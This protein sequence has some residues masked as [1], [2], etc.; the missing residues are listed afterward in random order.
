[1]ILGGESP[2]FTLA[3]QTYEIKSV[4]FS[5]D[6][7]LLAAAYKWPITVQIWNVK[8]H[9][10]VKTIDSD[11]DRVAFSPDGQSLAIGGFISLN[12][13]Q[14]SNFTEHFIRL[15]STEAQYHD[16][17][18]DVTFSPNGQYVASGT[19]K[20]PPDKYFVEIWQVND[21]TLVQTLL[22]H[23]DRVNSIAFSLDGQYLASASTDG[24][25]RL[26]RTSNW[27]LINML[28]T[29]S[30][31]DSVAF[32]PDGQLLASGGT[33]GTILWR[34]DDG[35]KIATFDT[36]L[37]NSVAFSPDG[38]KLASG[39]GFQGHT[40][41][42]NSVAF[43]PDGKL[44]ASGSDDGT[45]RLW[46]VEAQAEHI[47]GPTQ[48]P[49]LIPTPLGGGSGV[50]AFVS[51]RDEPNPNTCSDNCNSE[52]YVMNADGSGQTPLTND[53]GQDRDPAWSPDGQRMAFT[54]RRD[55]NEEIYVMNADGS[56]QTRLTNNPETDWYPAWSPDG[57]RIAFS[58]VRN[59]D[60]EIYVMNADGSGQTRLTN[61]RATAIE[62]SWS[63]DGKRIAF[64]SEPEYPNPDGFCGCAIWVMNSDGSEQTRLTNDAGL[65]VD[66][67]WSPDGKYIVFSS[68]LI[69]NMNI[70]VMNADGSGEIRLTNKAGN[71]I[72][73]SWSPDGKY[74]VFNYYDS[75]SNDEIYVMNA[76]G[77]GQTPLTNNGAP[78]FDPT[79]QPAEK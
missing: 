68:G 69:D 46:E 79:W 32:S 22:G 49:T 5:P 57:Q 26:W 38:Q 55:G 20:F 3:G 78:D 7:K 48:A 56:G 67:S 52:I 70:H 40:G 28:N 15:S 25:I 71:E 66:P 1:L 72:Y 50:I 75:N 43:S 45:V 37:A 59:G 16:L 54:S 47:E 64:V 41:Q 17:T 10:T 58:S 23:T 29:Q 35:T 14:V 51:K 77:S 18:S 21:G 53:S 73:P 6:G 36:S 34:I 30:R 8:D 42:V 62:A 12:L 9:T 61:E 2:P 65:E 44:L 13:L 24:T 60:E 33:G 4:A 27:T 11:G 74:I 31:I 19:I 76:D 63:P 39:L